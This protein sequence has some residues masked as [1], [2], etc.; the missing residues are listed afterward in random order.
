MNK[1]EKKLQRENKI[2]CDENVS[3]FYENEILWDEMESA[4]GIIA[5]AHGGDWDLA[6]KASGWKKAAK[7][8]RNRYHFLLKKY[9]PILSEEPDVI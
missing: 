7:R 8:W 5:N 2:L 1:K 9:G 4:W 6:S 3:L